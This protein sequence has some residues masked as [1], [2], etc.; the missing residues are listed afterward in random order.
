MVLQTFSSSH[1]VAQPWR[2]VTGDIATA[3][4]QGKQQRTQP[5]YMHAPRD[6]LVSKTGCFGGGSGTI[7][8]IHGNVYGLANAPA[9]FSAS[10]VTRLQSVGF[11]SH[12]LDSML[13]LR[14]GSLD[15]TTQST[16][17]AL[18]GFH[19][20]DLIMTCHPAYP[21]EDVK[22]LFSWGNWVC[23]EP[24]QQKTIT[25]TGRQIQVLASG[26]V[27]ICQPAFMDTV[28]VKQANMR[29]RTSSALTSEEDRTAFRSATGTLQWLS[30]TSRPDVSAWCSLLQKAS[31]SIEDLSGLY[32]AI[33]H[34]RETAQQGISINPVP[35][36]SC[37]LIVYSDSS[38]ANAEKGGSQGGLCI[39]LCSREVLSGK[40]VVGSIVEWKSFKSKRICRSTLAAEAMAS[41]ASIDH[42]QF[43]ADFISMALSG[44]ALRDHKCIVPFA[45]LTDCKSLYDSV[46]Q[47]SPCLE[48]K[49]TILT[50]AAI[51]EA[52]VEN[53][54]L[55]AAIPPRLFWVP[56][57]QQRAD[58]LTKTSRAL[59]KSFLSWLMYPV[60]KL[61]D[62]WERETRE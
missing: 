46:L 22:S 19:V 53:H 62:C 5:V 47:S 54:A 29:G 32:D 2:L 13:F 55:H 58:A 3:F 7:Y 17:I 16:L 26:S 43:A 38:F 51:R 28:P 41:E 11:V 57:D 61:S 12:P 42:A 6:P 45:S 15:G 25:F 37:V 49:R 27:I 9:T 52:V 56:T 4:L 21:L 44:N 20:D 23:V 40:S 48:E 34:V 36:D 59:R 39:T 8:E 30:S 31:P 35:L 1:L 10:V 14:Y 24:G 60:I 18:A 50:V 33:A